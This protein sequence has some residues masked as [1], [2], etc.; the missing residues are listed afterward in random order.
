MSDQ[1]LTDEDRRIVR[2]L[3]F[4]GREFDR[5]RGYLIGEDEPGQDEVTAPEAAAP[6]ADDGGHEN[7][8]AVEKR[9]PKGGFARRAFG[10]VG[11]AARAAGRLATGSVHPRHPDWENAPL[12]DRIDWWVQRFGTATSAIAAVPGLG[13]KLGR[14]AGAGD[15]VGAAAQVLIVNAVAREMGVTDLG[16]RVATAARIVLGRD[17][18]PAA[19][20]QA[21]DDPAAQPNETLAGDAPDEKTGLLGRVGRTASL[22]WRV[23]KEVAH[24]RS[25]IGKRPQGGLFS[26]ALSNLPAVGVAGAFLSERRGI[27]RA[28]AQARDAFRS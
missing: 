2:V 20:E 21:V 4:S 19:V 22:V 17:L 11:S 24:L 6:E 15:V 14:I 10:T 9:K 7:E 1:T 26:R 16:R 8:G 13:G 28:A 27:S 23:A 25:D 3:A 18:D 5:V 12:Q